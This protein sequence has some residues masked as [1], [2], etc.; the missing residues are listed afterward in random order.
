MVDGAEGLLRSRGFDDVRAER[1][2]GPG[3][4]TAAA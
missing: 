2:W 1:F 4:A 3:Q